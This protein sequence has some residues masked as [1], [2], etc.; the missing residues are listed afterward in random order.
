MDFFYEGG[1]MVRPEES[2]CQ[3]Y[4]RGIVDVITANDSVD[5]FLFQEVDFN[6]KRSYYQDQAEIIASAI[7]DIN[8]FSAINYKSDYIPVPYLNPMGKVN[9]GLMI[10]SKYNPVECFR[11]SMP[12]T[13]SWPKKLF[14]PKRC[15]L[16]SKFGIA[17]ASDLVLLNIHNSAYDDADAGGEGL[18]V[19]ARQVEGVVNDAQHLEQAGYRAAILLPGALDVQM[20]LVEGFPGAGVLQGHLDVAGGGAQQTIRPPAFG[21]D[22]EGHD[23]EHDQEKE[24]DALAHGTGADVDLQPEAAAGG[25]ERGTPAAPP[26]IMSRRR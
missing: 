6:S 22:N 16:I 8:Y 11:I 15:I 13:Y 3:K 23:G 7:S 14:M 25:P 19:L 5:F 21:R 4:I 24:D 2:L 10:V 17:D 20:Y 9:S 1:K 12:L 18:A 26:M